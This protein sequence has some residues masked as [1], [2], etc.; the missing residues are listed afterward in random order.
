MDETFDRDKFTAG[1]SG[2]SGRLFV[3]AADIQLPYSGLECG[4]LQSET[5]GGA[6]RPAYDALRLFQ[7]SQNPFALGVQHHFRI[8]SLSDTVARQ[9]LGHGDRQ[10]FPLSQND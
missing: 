9:D 2:S 1:Q 6:I 4:T 5:Y 7:R 3:S 8:V 10:C